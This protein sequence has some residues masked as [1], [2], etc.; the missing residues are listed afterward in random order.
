MTTT[1]NPWDDE[2]LVRHAARRA[3][4]RVCGD[5][6]GVIAA[7]P[8]YVNCRRCLEAVSVG[9]NPIRLPG[10]N[11]RSAVDS[12]ERVGECI[13]S[14]ADAVRL[15]LPIITGAVVDIRAELKRR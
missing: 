8:Q 5:E 14:I 4:G 6:G 3:G 9:P 2:P 1:P 15:V 11:D 7:G 13:V 10:P 12:A